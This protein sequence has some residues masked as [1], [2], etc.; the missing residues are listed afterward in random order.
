MK[1]KDEILFLSIIKVKN[2]Y[3]VFEPR[4]GRED[5]GSRNENSWVAEDMATLKNVINDIFEP[6]VPVCTT[7]FQVQDDPRG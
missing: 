2:G 3:Q 7:C 5:Y 1:N 4:P 6:S